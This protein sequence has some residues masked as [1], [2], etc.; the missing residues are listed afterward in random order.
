VYE[1]F[2]RHEIAMSASGTVGLLGA[3]ANWEVTVESR[4]R[5][6]KAVASYGRTQS[7]YKV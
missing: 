7:L 4:K 3:D 6:G 5:Y 1:P 2:D